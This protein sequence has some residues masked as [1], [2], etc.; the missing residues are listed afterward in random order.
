MLAYRKCCIFFFF[1]TASLCGCSRWPASTAD[2][3]T[4]G[5]ALSKGGYE[6]VGLS[7]VCGNT[8]VAVVGCGAV[9]KVL[10][11]KAAAP[12]IGDEKAHAMVEASGVLGMVNNVAVLSGIGNTEAKLLG[13]IAAAV[14]YQQTIESSDSNGHH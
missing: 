14:M 10:T 2:L 8:P 6:E 12:V 13:L 3:A 5:Y 1:L 7:R 11:Y 9:A 4:T